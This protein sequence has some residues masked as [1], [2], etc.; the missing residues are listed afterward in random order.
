[1]DTGK[2]V[3]WRIY[4]TDGSGY[5]SSDTKWE[6]LPEDGVIVLVLYLDEYSGGGEVQHRIVLDGSDYYFHIPGTEL[7]GSNNDM[8]DEIS[9]RYPGA[10]IKRGKWTES[11]TF[12]ATKTE[13]MKAKC[14]SK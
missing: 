13:A 6:D 8:P 2:V 7:F 14:P 10:I 11:S 3:G 1:M 9:E 4:Y 12:K 5:N